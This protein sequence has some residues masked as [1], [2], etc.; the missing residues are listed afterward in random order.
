MKPVQASIVSI[1]ISAGN[2]SCEGAEDRLVHTRKQVESFIRMS[3]GGRAA[4][5]L[6]Y[7]EEDG[8]SSGVQR[9]FETGTWWAR[10]MVQQYGMDEKTDLL[11]FGSEACLEGPLAI[12]VNKAMEVN[13]AMDRIIKPQMSRTI[14]EL[15]SDRTVLDSL[16]EQLLRRNRL[17]REALKRIF[18]SS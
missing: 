9:D 8:C 11:A 16:A 18:G 2:V 13:K 3:L 14:E 5:I 12:R 7:G 10:K 15:R 4:E 6:F 17:S 1:G